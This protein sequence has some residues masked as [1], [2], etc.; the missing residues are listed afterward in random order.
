M[1][2]KVFEPG[3][4]VSGASLGAIV[5]GFRKYP[6]VAA[7]YLTRHGL[8]KSVAG[9]P[10]DIDRDGWYPLE[11]WLAAYEGIANEIGLNSLFGIGKSIPENAT[12]PPHVKDI[13]SGI[14]SIDVAYHMNHRKNGTVMFNPETGQMLDGIGHYGYEAASDDDR[15][16]C[17]CHN[18]YPCDFDRGIITAMATRF[19]PLARTVHDNDAPCRKSGA[20][21]CT[22]VVMW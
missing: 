10:A 20:D 2:F 12:F 15:I 17:V 9:K 6:T 21:S 16:V 18:P 3:I 1:Q 8:V 7:K 13:H 11:D 4:Q 19:Q 14:S 22:Y 5:E